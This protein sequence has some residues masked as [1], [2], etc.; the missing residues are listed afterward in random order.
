MSLQRPIANVVKAEQEGGFARPVRSRQPLGVF[1]LLGVGVLLVFSAFAFGAVHL[2]SLRIA[3]IWVF[4]LGLAWSGA[5]F[6]GERRLALGAGQRS[7]FLGLCAAIGLLASVMVAQMVPLPPA[8]LKTVSS[9]TYRF[10]QRTVVGWPC[11]SGSA[12]DAARGALSPRAARA[13]VAP[14]AAARQAAPAPSAVEESVLPGPGASAS[15]AAP[16][17]AKKALSAAPAGAVYGCWRPLSLDPELTESSLIELAAYATLFVLV[18]AASGGRDEQSERY[19]RWLITG[20]IG[21]GFGLALLAQVEW[22]TWNGKLLWF[23]VPRDWEGGN[24]PWLARASGPF[25]NPDHFAAYEALIFPLAVCGLMAPAF[26]APKR[27]AEATRVLFGLAAFVMFSA[28]VLTLSRAGWF[29]ALLGLAVVGALLQ[30]RGGSV[31]G[32]ASAG[33]AAHTRLALALLAVLGLAG[34]LWM[35]GPTGRWEVDTRLAETLSFSEARSGLP[36]RWDAWRSSFAM[37]RHFPLFGVGLGAWPE[38]VLRYQLPPW[39]D[40]FFREAHNDYLQVAAEAGLAGIG[41]LGYAIFAAARLLRRGARAVPPAQWPIFAGLVAGIAALAVHEFVDFSFRVPAVAFLVTTMLALAVAMGSRAESAAADGNELRFSRRFAV[42]AGATLVVLIIAALGQQ[43]L[44]YPYA[45]GHPATA[46][47]ALNLISLHPANAD[48]H[49]LLADIGDPS[50][51]AA[52]RIEQ[53]RIASWLDP[54]NPY[55]RDELVLALV[56]RGNVEEALAEMRRALHLS[57]NYDYHWYLSPEMLPQLSGAARDAIVEGLQSAQRSGF[58]GATS[59]LGYYYEQSGQWLERAKLYEDAAAQA[60]SVEAKVYD[61]IEAARSFAQAGQRADAERCLDEARRQAPA[62][63][64]PYFELIEL[65]LAPEKRFPEAQALVQKGAQQGVS[66]TALWKALAA[67]A[68]QVSDGKVERRA[69]RRAIELDPYDAE[70][71]ARLGESYLT[72]QQCGRAAQAFRRALDLKPRDA[73]LYRQLGMA[74]EC[75]FDYPAAESAYARAAALDPKSPRF[76]AALRDFR[77]RMQAGIAK[78]N[79][80]RPQAQNVP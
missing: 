27:R 48:A 13:P 60:P 59:A 12:G 8:V 79:A 42:V 77:A 11:G 52:R 64:K 70:A 75:D 53:L 73:G 18:L 63:P 22:A 36:G 4:A 17:G 55:R 80:A 25:V 78:L 28:L 10:Y 16:L 74:E 38:V 31:A 23:F 49:R 66:A 40:T 30:W 14:L 47:Q 56:Q 62:D 67:A 45:L 51:G 3:E 34:A 50:L 6:G 19:R 68:S 76:A 65:V 5:I 46:A 41:L 37:L 61:L 1:L 15:S 43:H 7:A 29:D 58:R 72:A 69:L 26:V 44:R 24:T 71:V 20:V 2:W 32:R 39:S 35:V 21:V 54:L 33:R 57:P 9:A